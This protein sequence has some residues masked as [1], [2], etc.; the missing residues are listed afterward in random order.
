MSYIVYY[1]FQV[2]LRL[3][4]QLDIVGLLCSDACLLWCLIDIWITFACLALLWL[5]WWCL[6]FGYCC[7]GGVLAWVLIVWLNCLCLFVCDWSV[8][9]D[10]LWCFVD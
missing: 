7:I 5:V 6:D 3:A 1:I 9:A 4:L 10:F 2:L 8:F